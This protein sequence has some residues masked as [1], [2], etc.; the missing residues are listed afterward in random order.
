M[1]EKILIAL[2]LDNEKDASSVKEILDGV[3]TLSPDNAISYICSF[4]YDKFFSIG[5]LR[6]IN[7]PSLIIEDI[8][9]DEYMKNCMSINGLNNSDYTDSLRL[10]IMGFSS[11]DE[12]ELVVDYSECNIYPCIYNDNLILP[13]DDYSGMFSRM[14]LRTVINTDNNSIDIIIGIDLS[15]NS[16]GVKFDKYYYRKY[17]YK[18]YYK[19]NSL[20]KN[21]K[22][23]KNKYII[24][25]L[26]SNNLFNSFKD[27][28]S[29]YSITYFEAYNLEY[30]NENHIGLS[31]ICDG[32][33]AIY[34]SAY[35][36]NN[37]RCDLIIPNGI[38]YVA[39]G[40]DLEDAIK[41]VVPP[42]V[43]DIEFSRPL[44]ETYKS[45]ITLMLSRKNYNSLVGSLYHKLVPKSDELF[46]M[47]SHIDVAIKSLRKRGLHIEVYG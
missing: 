22:V 10:N 46:C 13:S 8:P 37:A 33:I 23:Y 16:I 20:F 31:R 24:T 35:I 34:D 4:Y 42:S 29:F 12:F 39:I 17:Y 18:Y 3:S 5:A 19:Y 38:K 2:I 30:Y 44:S 40:K 1:S 21:S 15:N 45:C 36:D 11:V 14:E 6:V 32:V 25:N 9:V 28:E 47:E 26:S 43:I 7:I 27:L 41:I